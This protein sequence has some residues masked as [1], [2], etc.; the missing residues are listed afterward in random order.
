MIKVIS[1]SDIRAMIIRLTN[2]AIKDAEASFKRAMSN[3]EARSAFKSYAWE[4]QDLYATYQKILTGCP[5][6]QS[7]LAYLTNFADN[8]DIPT[9]V[10]LMNMDT[11]YLIYA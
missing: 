5:T 11:E 6:A 4:L 2:S 1:N 9:I 3:P 7:F 10:E 8:D